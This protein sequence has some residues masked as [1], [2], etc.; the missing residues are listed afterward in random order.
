MTFR[1]LLSTPFARLGF[2]AGEGEPELD[3]EGDDFNG[4]CEEGA[5]VVL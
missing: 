5:R 1:T 3:R 4:A 2:E